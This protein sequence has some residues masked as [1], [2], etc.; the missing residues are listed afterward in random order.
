MGWVESKILESLN[1]YL[2][3]VSQRTHIK[4]TNMLERLNKKIKR[5]T[6]VERIFP[7]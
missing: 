7:N 5:R 2:F 4:S 1:F 3:L 6:L